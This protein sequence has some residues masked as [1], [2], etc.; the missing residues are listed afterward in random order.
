[1][2]TL[3]RRLVLNALRRHC[4]LH[5]F[6]GSG[7]P[8]AVRRAQRL[9]ASLRSARPRGRSPTWASRRAQRL[10]ASL[11][12]ARDV[13]VP[14]G[15]VRRACSTPCGVTAICTLA[16]VARTMRTCVLNALRRHCDLHAASAR[17]AAAGVCSTPCGVTAI[18]T[19]S[20]R[21]SPTPFPLCSTPCGVTAICTPPDRLGQLPLGLVLNALRRHCDLHA[22]IPVGCTAGSVCSTPCGVTAIC[23]G[24]RRQ[25]GR[26]KGVLNA[27]RRHCDLHKVVADTAGAKAGCST[28]CGVT[29]ICTPG[30]AS[31]DIGEYSAQRLAASLRSALRVG[32]PAGAGAAVL[33]ALRRH[34]D[35]HGVGRDALDGQ[36]RVLNALRRHCD[37][38]RAPTGGRRSAGRC[39]QRLAASLR[40][41]PCKRCHAIHTRVEV[42]NALRRHCDLHTRKNYTSRTNDQC[43]TPCGVTAICTRSAAANAALLHRCSTPCGVTAICTAR[44]ASP[45]TPTASAQRLAAS[46]RSAQFLYVGHSSRG[47]VLNAL[48]RHCDLHTARTKKK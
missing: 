21:P 47:C 45:T 31:D 19:T 25:R 5:V 4:D 1:M 40:S 9:A 39:A 38:H 18:C 43:S 8:A 41:A 12:S 42:L 46:L 32:Q 6:V 11:R 16:C 14:G 22:R 17:L 29:A 10:A 44:R 26:Q 15:G 27:L 28:P 23:T 36:G 34:C 30:I 37:L 13:R 48:R 2:L 3:P 7:R 33:N 20:P 35:L 24:D